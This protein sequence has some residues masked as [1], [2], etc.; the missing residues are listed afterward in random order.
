[1][2]TILKFGRS[3]LLAVAALAVLA[4]S[5]HVHTFA[6][7]KEVARGA[8][9]EVAQAFQRVGASLA[10]LRGAIGS[11]AFQTAVNLQMGF[12]VIG[13]WALEGPQRAVPA[14]ITHGTAADIVVGRWFTYSSEGVVRPG[15]TGAK[16]GVLM[17]PKNYA[18]NGQG[19]IALAPGLVVPT[20]TI[21]EFG[22]MG[23][24]V[25]AAPAAVAL[26]A[27]A[28]YDNITGVIGVGT[29]GGG[30]TQIPNARFVRNV[31]LA[32]GLAILELTQ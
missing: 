21:G 23:S 24:I 14:T 20:G 6:A 16:C 28:F 2:K 5:P 17:N 32:A 26:D 29:A 3:A 19:G 22:Y 12:G 8:A 7:A 4:V 11:Y 1:M 10:Q 31:N 15:G 27:T 30:Q 13:E 25:I 18:N 9:S